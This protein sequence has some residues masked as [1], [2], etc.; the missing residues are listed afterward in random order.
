MFLRLLSFTSFLL[1]IVH[2]AFAKMEIWAQPQNSILKNASGW[3]FYDVLALIEGFLLKVALPLV[4][5]G[6]FLYVAYKLFLAEGNEEEN[7]KAWKAVTYASIGIISIMVAYAVIA[8][9]S[10]VSI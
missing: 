5:V 2:D 10:R 6:T 1:V 8:I 7:K 9:V 4:I 3:T